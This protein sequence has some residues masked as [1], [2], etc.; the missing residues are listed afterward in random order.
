M[1]ELNLSLKGSVFLRVINFK[2]YIISLDEFLW[3]KIMSNNHNKILNE[4]QSLYKRYSLEIGNKLVYHFTKGSALQSIIT[5]NELWLHERNYMNDILDEQFTRLLIS[6]IISECDIKINFN[7]TQIQN[8]FYINSCQYI[9][10]TSMESDVIN[11]WIYYGS[12]N[13]YCIEFENEKLCEYLSDCLYHGD[14]IYGGTVIYDETASR[15]ILKE[16]IYK[17]KNRYFDKESTEIIDIRKFFEGELFRYVF[18]YFYCFIKKNGNRYENEYR[19]LLKTDRTP[20]F[21]FSKG[22]FIPYIP[23]KGKNNE[24]LP[25]KRIIVGPNNNNEEQ[26]KKGL[27]MFL[28]SNGYENTEI[29]LSK[30]RIRSS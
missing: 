14:K 6:E 28:D 18:E 3:R 30:L 8:L 25:I 23:I 22:M 7:E 5:N 27:R 20:C 24:K 11:Q 16:V 4:I 10:S 15:S 17:Y 12:D 9:F 29:T 21:S 26:T 13:A 1:I 19:Y 2:E